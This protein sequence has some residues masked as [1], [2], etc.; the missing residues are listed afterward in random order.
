MSWPCAVAALAGGQ[1]LHEWARHAGQGTLASD[2]ARV[3]A[4]LGTV[5]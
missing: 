3:P 1:S 4:C 5:P 2:D